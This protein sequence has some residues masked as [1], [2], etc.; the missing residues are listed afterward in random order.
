MSFGQCTQSWN[1]NHSYNIEQL[2]PLFQVLLCFSVLSPHPPSKRCLPATTDLTPPYGVGT[3]PAWMF[4]RWRL[5]GQSSRANNTRLLLWRSTR[6][7][8][9]GQGHSL[10]LNLWS[11]SVRLGQRT[12]WVQNGRCQWGQLKHSWIL[13]VSWILG[14]SWSSHVFPLYVPH[15]HALHNLPT[16]FLRWPAYLSKLPIHFSCLLKQH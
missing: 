2:H 16:M 11:S 13:T 4:Q 10:P 5:A 7:S 6:A 1:Y 3:G 15:L 12:Y 9:L 14:A 8:T